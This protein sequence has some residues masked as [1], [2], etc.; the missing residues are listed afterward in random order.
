MGKML[1]GRAKDHWRIAKWIVRWSAD[2]PKFLHSKGV[3]QDSS[4]SIGRIAEPLGDPDLARLFAISG[5][6]WAHLCNKS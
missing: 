6:F 2:R 1:I 3:V 5:H 4:P